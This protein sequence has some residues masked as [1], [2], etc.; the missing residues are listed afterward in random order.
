MAAET[1]PSTN[2]TARRELVR[3]RQAQNQ[4]GSSAS[5]T[6]TSISNSRTV[7][8]LSHVQEDHNY[9]EPGPST[10]R[11][12]R[13]IVTNLSR[14]QRNPDELDIPIN[15]DITSTPLVDPL[16]L[17]DNISGRLRH[18]PAHNTVR[19]DSDG[20]ASD[21]DSDNTPL[22]LM[23]S[24][25]GQQ[26]STVGMRGRPRLSALVVH[27][28]SSA[29]SARSARSQKRPYYNEDSDDDSTNLRQSNYQQK[30]P[31]S[32]L[33][34]NPHASKRR[35]LTNRTIDYNEEE[36]DDDDDESYQPNGRSQPTNG[37]RSRKLHEEPESDD[38]DDDE[39][40][41]QT[42][43]VSSRGRVRKISAK[44][45]GYFRE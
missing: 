6:P 23:V 40:G 43:S 35:M 24:S 42:V 5:L 4:S 12:S 14:H 30:T 8:V 33:S 22:H 1:T 45:R 9:G 39:D 38:E 37:G 16:R 32:S 28:N 34:G 41:E 10:L 7:A 29:A 26:S 44:V 19:Q 11:H 25:A 17:P 2:G 27:N 13:R 21:P 3:R 18:R 31:N 20:E 36:D 15:S